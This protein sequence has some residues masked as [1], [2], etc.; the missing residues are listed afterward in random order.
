MSE[1]RSSTVASE[2]VRFGAISSS[3]ELADFFD[4][5]ETVTRRCNG[6]PIKDEYGRFTGRREECANEVTL[7]KGHAEMA[8][9]SL[10]CDKCCEAWNYK[11]R[12]EE[13]ADIW[14]RWLRENAERYEHFSTDH[15]DFNHKAYKILKK[16][17]VSKN[18]ILFGPTG[19]GKTFLMLQ[20]MKR[21]LWSGRMPC[22][23]WADQLK[24][25]TRGT[26]HW[27]EAQQYEQAGILGIEELF[28]E[29]SAR[30]AYTS[31]VRNL[32]DIRLRLRKPTI[33]TTQLKSK[34]LAGEMGK[35]DNET[36]ADVER[37]NAILRRINEDYY[38][39]DTDRN[40][41]YG[42]DSKF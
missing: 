14:K 12:V 27:R 5:S 10:C 37:R 20:Q 41:D 21:A 19:T 6:L 25:M 13:C 11:R 30:E 15:E 29:D 1:G 2:P 42:V 17:P 36:K 28:G 18:V 4:E 26:P 16:Q 3:S 8:G 40:R 31:F 35:Y 23:L 32:I 39:L 34:D 24:K 22:V 33:I 9:S 7:P 38:A